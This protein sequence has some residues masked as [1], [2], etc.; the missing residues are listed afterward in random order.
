M[1]VVVDVLRAT[2]AIV[3]G[4][5]HGV[6]VMV[7]VAG[8]EETLSYKDK[9]YL[10]AGE[11]NGEMQE[12]FDFGNSPFS[13][14]PEV[15][16]GRNVAIST[17]NGTQAVVAAKDS[18]KLFIGAFL[19]ISALCKRILNENRDVIVLC[20][21]WKNKFNLEDTLFA[22]ALAEKL[23]GNGYLLNCDSALAAIEL[24]KNAKPDVNAFLATSSHRN[25]L[26]HLDLEAD[27]KYCLTLD[28][29]KSVPELEAGVLVWKD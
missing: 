15:V 11:R 18:H 6:N 19:N 12:G 28:L 25:R 16:K 5:D 2:S 1:V 29:C 20:A 13:Y 27:I 7:A 14:K 23:A 8:I 3:T 17:T 9:G 21:G 22:G 26:K 4:F 10:V 24:W